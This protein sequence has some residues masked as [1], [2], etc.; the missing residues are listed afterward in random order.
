[1][2]TPDIPQKAPYPV[3]VEAGQKYWW[4]ACGRSKNQP[5]CDGSHKGTP[6]LP[7]EFVAEKSEKVWFCGC[8]HT[9]AAP[10][11]DGTHRKL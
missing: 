3:D 8:K 9:A 4:C 2:N 6:F 1:M 5:F 10:L 7:V 11:C